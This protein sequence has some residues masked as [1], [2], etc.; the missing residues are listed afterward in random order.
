MLVLVICGSLI[1]SVTG[2][3]GHQQSQYLP[4][5]SEN[6]AKSFLHHRHVRDLDPNASPHPDYCTYKNPGYETWCERHIPYCQGQQEYT[7]EHRCAT[8][9]TPCSPGHHCVLTTPCP[10]HFTHAC[11]D[12]NEC[13]SSPCQNGGTCHNG[14]N[15]YTCTCLPGWTGA[16]CEIDIDE[17]ASTPCMYGNDC[18][19]DRINSYVCVCSER[20]EGVHCERDCR[21]GPADVMFLVDTS[22][23]QKEAINQSVDFMTEFVKQIP[24]GPNDF[25]VSVVSFSLHPKMSFDFTTYQSNS[26]LLSA[27]S[28]IKSE[29]G[30]T[31]TSD[32]LQ[33]ASQEL[34]N[35]AN[36][37]RLL[38]N[39]SHY[40]ILL[41]N[42]L[43]TD[44]SQAIN[45]AQVL[46]NTNSRFKIYAVGIGE[47]IGHDELVKLPTDASLSFSPDNNDLLLAML[48]DASDYG[49]TDCN[50]TT[51]TD[52]IIL[53]DTS[54]DSSPLK[55][56]SLHSLKFVDKLVDSFD[57][58]HTYIKVAMLTFSSDSQIKFNFSH[59]SNQDMKAKIFT[60]TV[61]KRQGNT[62]I[63]VG[64]FKMKEL[65]T[66]P[67]SGSRPEARKIGYLFSNGKWPSSENSELKHKIEELNTAGISVNVMVTVDDTD[68]YSDI[69][70]SLT[71]AKEIAF[72]PY[73]VY[74]VEENNEY[75]I[76]Q[77]AAR[78]TRYVKCP[79]DIFESK[80]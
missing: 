75:V 70:R 76:I 65:F 42:G 44:R 69:E 6:K 54:E 22:F 73:R 46:R 39:I 55:G 2:H 27:L 45:T 48:K 32:A 8:L 17:C 41:T 1:L 36:G 15:Q 74:M 58:T 38:S 56:S 80:H 29:S 57:I 12:I 49:C 43:S 64:L 31:K 37:A 10:A 72:D 20:F 19:Q 52:V 14:N 78:E 30:P 24:I 13:D 26:S 40:V 60:T 53:F 28:L 5:I 4:E 3:G 63:H 59:I 79:S 34:L 7:R 35:T 25:Q 62:S 9:S 16:N 50:S 67:S 66:S 61:D 47:D 68:S 77:A 33:Y 21:P 23:S 51:V 71:N 18:I 11:V